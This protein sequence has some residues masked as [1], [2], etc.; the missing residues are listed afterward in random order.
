MPAPPAKTA[1]STTVPPPA[2]DTGEPAIPPV[3]DEAA[4]PNFAQLPTPKDDRKALAPGPRRDLL[5]AAAR[6][7]LPII[8]NGQE[9]A[10]VYARPFT[11]AKNTP[12]IAIVVVGLGLSQEAT[13]AAVTKLPADIS[14]SFSPYAGGIGQWVRKARDSGHEVL[15]DLPLEPPNFPLHDAGPLAVLAGQSPA[16]ATDRLEAILG[17][18]DSYVGVA[19]AL[20]SPVTASDA[21][22]PMLSDLRDRGLLFV[23]DGLVGVADA[24]MPAAGSVTLVVDE[25]P[26]RASIDARLGRLLLA[27]QRDGYAI[28]YA[29]ARPV[30]FERL[31][32]WAESLAEKGVV[33]APVSAVVRNKP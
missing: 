6:G 8:A 32:A 27:A 30:T 22:A 25:T 13:N 28:G 11:A 19:A 2:P 9:A 5:S 18:A 3:G 17:K 10:K 12:R 21:W 14:L 26:F 20:K 15:M 31:I 33:L 4:P 7:S 29:S 1:T 24:N 23:G 16:E